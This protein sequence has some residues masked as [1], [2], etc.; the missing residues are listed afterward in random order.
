MRIATGA[1]HL[2]PNHA[3]GTVHLKFHMVGRDR[4]KIAWPAR[5][6]IKLMLMAKKGKPAG[7]AM[8]YAVFI[9]IPRAREWRLGS[10]LAHH[11]ELFRC[12]YFFP[13]VFTFFNFLE[14]NFCFAKTDPL[15]TA[16]AIDSR[17]PPRHQSQIC[18]V[19]LIC[20]ERE[21]ASPN[22]FD[23]IKFAPRIDSGLRFAT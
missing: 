10:M 18:I 7:G 14:H 15:R 22:F 2:F 20:L 21:A 6:G 11:P 1:A 8:I 5:A 17:W 12:Q 4:L 19:C 16:F 9:F 3:M 23:F 13:L